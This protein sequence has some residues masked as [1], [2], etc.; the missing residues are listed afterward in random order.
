MSKIPEGTQYIEVGCGEKGFRKYEKG[1]W[2]FFEGFWRRV[3]W[4]MGDLKPVTEHHFYIDPEDNWT[5]EGRPPAGTV[6]EV[7]WNDARKEY[8]TCVVVGVEPD[9]GYPVFRFTGKHKT[10]QYQSDPLTSGIY[11]TQVFRPIRTAEQI[12][13]DE[14]LHKVR[15]ALSS[16]SGVEEWNVNAE[17]STAIRATVEAMIDAGYRK[18]P[19]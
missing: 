12:A 16:I 13:A 9:T 19:T 6:C 17:A 10:N 5:G 2:W 18:E 8:T 4:Q 14:R 11:G 7:L 15:N 1:C 3:D